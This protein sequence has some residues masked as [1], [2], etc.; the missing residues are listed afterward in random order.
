MNRCKKISEFESKEAIDRSMD[1]AK[2][3]VFN[4]IIE[5]YKFN[6][7]EELLK[8]TKERNHSEARYFVM[9]GLKI[10][11]F[12]EERI[13]IEVKRNHSSFINGLNTLDNLY[14][15]NSTYRKMI[16]DMDH[17]FYE[18]RDRLL[19]II[20]DSN[21]IV[22]NKN[23]DKSNKLLVMYVDSTIM[24]ELSQW[25]KDSFKKSL[26][27]KTKDFLMDLRSRIKDADVK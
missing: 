18:I 13:L 7:K 5:H 1:V 25:I 20:N 15:T 17:F 9:R 11:G 8:K 3:E 10:I 6:S 16:I 23:T 4:H 21:K 2:E 19:K 26:T 14:D 22:V 24:S 27:K 12:Q